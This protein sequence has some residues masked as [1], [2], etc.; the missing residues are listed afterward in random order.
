MRRRLLL[1]VLALGSVLGYASALC[2][3]GGWGRRHSGDWQR[4]MAAACVDAV[5]AQQATPA[6]RT[7]DR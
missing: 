3:P 6:K 7:G 1:G 4:Q 2:H 5:L